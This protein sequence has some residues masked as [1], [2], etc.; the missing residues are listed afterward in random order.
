M[1]GLEALLVFGAA[2]YQLIEKAKKI[3]RH[4]E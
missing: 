3:R 1:A 4:E 2:D